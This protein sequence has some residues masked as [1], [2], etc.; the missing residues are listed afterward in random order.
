VGRSRPATRVLVAGALAGVLW[1]GGVAAATFVGT[2]S[3]ETPPPPGPDVAASLPPPSTIRRDNPPTTLNTPEINFGKPAA[4]RRPQRPAGLPGAELLLADDFTTKGNGWQEVRPE[5]NSDGE[6]KVYAD[7]GFRMVTTSSDSES[8]TQALVELRG[9][10]AEVD[11]A[12]GGDP[13]GAVTVGLGEQNVR[14]RRD[15]KVTV[16]QRPDDSAKKPEVLEAATSKTVRADGFN[17]I[18]VTCRAVD[19]RTVRITVAVNGEPVA[20]VDG[21]R[22]SSVGFNIGAEAAPGTRPEP[23]AVLLDNLALWGIKA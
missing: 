5:E 22:A 20:Q 10:H 16:E 4:P 13:I 18:A 9:V 1:V 2:R 7:G 12:F 8:P 15:G 6:S 3:G 21:R 11:V 14:V 23:T 17:R 19:Q